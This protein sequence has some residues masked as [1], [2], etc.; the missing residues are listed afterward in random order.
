MSEFQVPGPGRATFSGLRN[1][2]V[3]GSWRIYGLLNS[4]QLN[5]REAWER[6]SQV[7]D[8]IRATA[9]ERGF[10]EREGQPEGL[11]HQYREDSEGSGILVRPWW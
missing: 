3:P 6:A 5:R 9:G 10:H 8:K 2:L 4:I 1:N 11:S 7:H